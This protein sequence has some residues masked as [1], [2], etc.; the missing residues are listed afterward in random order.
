MMIMKAYPLYDSATKKTIPD[1]V[2]FGIPTRDTVQDTISED[3]LADKYYTDIFGPSLV[4]ELPT[5]P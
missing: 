3:S 4:R 5:T 2:A 1:T